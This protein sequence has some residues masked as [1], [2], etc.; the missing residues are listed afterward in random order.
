MQALSG[1][2]LFL[3]RGFALGNPFGALQFGAVFFMVTG[4]HG[5]H[6]TIGVIFLIITA[7]KVK[8]RL[9]REDPGFMTEAGA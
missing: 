1:V 5:T 6:V 2:S 9:D 3:M 8:R 7:V 4:F